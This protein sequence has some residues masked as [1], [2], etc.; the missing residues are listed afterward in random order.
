MVY[1]ANIY[2]LQHRVPDIWAVFMKKDF[3]FQKPSV[4]GMAIGWDHAGE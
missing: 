2:N 4:P 3:N 1:I